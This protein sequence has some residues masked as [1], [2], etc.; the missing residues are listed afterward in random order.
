MPKYGTDY[1]KSALDLKNPLEVRD[2][3]LAYGKA[4]DESD[5][6]GDA[7]DTATKALPE[8]LAFDKAIIVTDIAHNAVKEAIDRCGSY[9]M[10]K[11]GLYALK[12]G[13]TSVTYSVKTVRELIP[14]YAKAVIAEEVDA[15]KFNGLVK[16]GLVTEAQVKAIEIKT[17]LA[18]A[19]IIG[20]A[21]VPEAEVPNAD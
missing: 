11:E 1:T 14:D 7:Y 12:Q 2:L 21:T 5:A 19:Y 10:I 18:P 15:R 3:L 13:R 20:L 8:T 9:Q 17:P 16:G 6:A 4:K